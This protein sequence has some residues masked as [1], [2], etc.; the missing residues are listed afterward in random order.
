M[1]YLYSLVRKRYKLISKKTWPNPQNPNVKESV[2]TILQELNLNDDVRFGTTKI[3]IRSPK[4]VFILET[5]RSERIPQIV[6]YI[7]KVG[8]IK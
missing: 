8:G 5:K 7:Q 2:G 6:I 4:T 1:I 3:F